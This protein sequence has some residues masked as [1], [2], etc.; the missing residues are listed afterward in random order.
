MSLF[1][2]KVA[3]MG[4]ATLLKKTLRHRC[5]P[6]SLAKFLKTPVFIEHFYC[7]SLNPENISVKSLVDFK[8]QVY[9]T[10]HYFTVEATS[11]SAPT[12]QL[13][14]NLMLISKI[15]TEMCS[16]TAR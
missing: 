12:L 5:F 10:P 2:N 14:V 13:I 15:D 7:L 3:E 11:I 16:F 4:S 8:N 9:Q 6:V 1:F